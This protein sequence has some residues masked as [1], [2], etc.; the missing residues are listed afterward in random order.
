MI[1]RQSSGHFNREKGHAIGSRDPKKLSKS[2]QKPGKVIFQEFLTTK[3]PR[4]KGTRIFCCKQT[5]EK[6]DIRC[7][8]YG[9]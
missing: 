3:E 8:T 5:Q 2:Q 7:R 6:K 9:A 1:L 4:N